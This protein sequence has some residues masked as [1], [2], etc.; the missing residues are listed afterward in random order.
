MHY[1]APILCV[2]KNLNIYNVVISH[3]PFG[4]ILVFMLLY[5]LYITRFPLQIQFNKFVSFVGAVSFN[6]F[7][8][9]SDSGVH[10]SE[11]DKDNN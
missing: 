11:R 8:D 2:T 10:C 1:P 4:N 9:F 7:H 6:P 5:S 3:P